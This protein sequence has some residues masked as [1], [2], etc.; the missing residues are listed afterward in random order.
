MKRIVTLLLAAGLVLGAAAGSQAADIK[1][2]GNWTFTW[3]LGDQTFAKHSGKDNFTAKQRLRTQIDVIASES[4]KGV[5]FLEMGDQNWGKSNDGASLGT[6]GKIIKVRYSYVDWVIPQ[7]DAKVRMGLQNFSLP[8]FISNSPILGGG[9]ADG[10]GITLSGQF[11]ENVGASLFW[12]RAENDNNGEYRGNPSSNAMDFVGLTVPMTFDGVKVTPWAMYGFV[13]RDSFENAGAS[14]DQKKLLQGLLPLGVSNKTLTGNSLTD[15]HG[16][17]W[18][19]G[20]TTEL[21]VLDPFRFALDATY[22]RVDLGEGLSTKGKKID[23][24]REGWIVSALAEYKMESVT[25]GLTAW[26]SSGDDANVNNGSERLPTINPDVKVTSYGFDGTN[27]CRAQQVLGTSVDGTFGIVAHLKDIS[28]FEDLS[29]TLRVAF[30]RGTNNTENVRQKMITKPSETVSS[31]YYMTTADKAWE[32]NVDSEY[33]IYKNLS[34]FLELG[35]IRMDL[36][37]NVWKDYESKKNN[38]KGAV[39]VLYSF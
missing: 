21:K 11:T 38:F 39:C 24:K 18:W 7:T 28:F 36:D 33:K 27:F 23:V 10:A 14:G 3:Q 1:A 9:A 16:D 2:K 37:S 34:L 20:F 30:Y 22:G 15:R 35:Y 32:A 8:G 17:A 5:L 19:A 6:D 12:L 25:P 4:L 13:G 29:H 31:M 26:Y